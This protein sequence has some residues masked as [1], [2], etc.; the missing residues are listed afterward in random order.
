MAMRLAVAYLFIMVPGGTPADENNWKGQDSVGPKIRKALGLNRNTKIYPIFQ[1]VLA[2]KRDCVTY[3]G[4]WDVESLLGRP[5]TR[6]LEAQ[7]IADS[8]KDG[9]GREH[10][11][12]QVNKYRKAQN[13][14]SFT[15]GAVSTCIKNLKPQVQRIGVKSQCSKDVNSKW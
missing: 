5:C 12:L 10:T 8:T 2:C 6:A 13:L 1:N 9:F 14:P 11:K 4:A 7:I 15:T 3:T